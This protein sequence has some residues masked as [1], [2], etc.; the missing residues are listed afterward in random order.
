MTARELL[1]FWLTF[2]Q[3]VG[4]R[5]YLVWGALLTLV[6]FAGDAALVW[7]GAGQLW[8]PADYLRS[9][10]L[11]LA[12]RLEGAPP[13][14]MPALALWTLPFLWIG[15][16][17]T[18][19]RALDAG[20]SAWTTLGFFVP[21]LN[22]VLMALLALLPSRPQPAVTRPV[23]AYDHRLPSALLAIG[24][25]LALG[26]GMLALSVATFERYGVALFFGT[27]FAVG[28]L[29]AFLFNR[30]YPASGRETV[31][32][33][34]MTFAVLAGA[35]FLLGT[36]GAVC[37]LMALP[38][39]L[40][41]GLMG[42]VL[43]RTVAL[44]GQRSVVPAAF[45]LLS[46]PTSAALEPPSGRVLHEVRSSV[47]VNASPD[48]VWRHVIAFDTIPEPRDLVFRLGVAYPR[49]ATLEGSGVGAVR[50]CGFSTGEFVE[51][52]T[53]WNPGRRLAF[54]VERAPAPLRELS[55][56]GGVAPPH[57]AGYLRSRRGEFRL[58]PLP[59]G[60]TRL[61]GSTWY[62]LSMAP[63]GYWQLFADYLIGRIHGR[64]LQHIAR[65]A[66]TAEA[67]LSEAQ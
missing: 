58:V 46:L 24:V 51:P 41:V 15:V 55:L 50:Y 59:G 47:D 22:Y 54:D 39:V 18:L 64:V 53:A 4:R 31:E 52:I 32:V 30:R 7:L 9:V 11:L 34:A 49:Y 36:E 29:T 6:K 42:G 17:M 43:G 63:E 57:L 1:R 38:L 19:R 3:P 28:A 10:P 13:W 35:I 66:E 26:L 67:T 5:E 48:R 45:A 8:T 14:L 33:T 62:E 12:T 40:V 56:H 60:R 23:R 16:T 25:G 37:L 44:R 2:E 61:E 65:E 21:Y 27:P 20:L